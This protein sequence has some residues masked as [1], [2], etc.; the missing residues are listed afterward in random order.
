M[1]TRVILMR[2]LAAAWSLAALLAGAAPAAAQ[3]ARAFAPRFSVNQ[4]GDIT[5]VG[6]T[7]M[8]CSGGGSCTNGRNGS[9]GKLNN[10]DFTMQYVDVDGDGSTFS[11]STADLALPAGATVT[12]AGLYWGGESSNALRNTCRFGTPI[13]GYTTLT[14]TQTDANGNDYG[15]FRD[16]T[17]L[18]QAAGVG[19]YRVANVYSNPGQS[20]KQAGW[21]L[22]V[23][24]R[25]ASQTPRNLVVFDGYGAVSAATN[26]TMTVSGFLTPPA[27]VVNTRLGVVALEGDLGYTGDAFQLNGTPLSD[28]NNP[29]NNFFNSS[30]S[31]LGTTVTAKNPD[32]LNQFGF[33]VDLVNANGMLANNA[34]SASIRLTSSNDAYYPMVVT[35]A[36]DLYAPV[37]DATN[38]TKTVVDLNG[39]DT[40]PGDLLE[41]TITM[42]NTGKDNATQCVMRDTLA[43]GLVYEPGSLQVVS[44][45]NAGVK[46]D[47]GGDDQM[48]YVA[49]SRTVVA[50]LGTGANA[51]SG[52]QIDINAVTSVRFRAR[53]ASP[54]P[55]GTVVSNQGWLAFVGGQ[56]GVAFAAASDG[57]AGASGTQP[58]TITVTSARIT[59][60]VFEDVNFGGG[61]GRTRAASAGVAR[62]GARVELYDAAGAALG[63]ATTDAAGLYTFDGW[64]AGSYQ[65]RVVNSSVTSSRPGSSAGL[66]PV[67]TFRTD[68]SGATAAPVADRV[69]GE[70]P[71]RA[72]AAANLAA[73]T[74]ASLTTATTT[75]QSVSPV[76]LGATDAT[77]VDFG[78]NF[79]TI[80]NANDAGQGSLRQFLLN[81]NA[82]T[83]AG[84]AQQGRTAGEESA[85]FMVSDGLAH[86]GLRAGLAN[87]LTGGVVRITVLSALPPLTD[88]ATRVDGGTQTS[89]VGDTNPALLGSGG[90]VGADDLA[91]PAL[92]GP[93]V[94]VRDGANLAVG[95]D[96]QAVSLALGRIAVLGFGNSPGSDAN[97]D[98]RVG[99][100][101]N[102][103][104]LESCA[105]GITATSFADPGAALRSGGDHVRVLGGD[106]GVITGS[107]LAYGTG[108]AVALTAGSNG[109]SLG[110]SELR[111]NTMAQPGLGAIVLAASGTLTASNTRISDHDGPGVDAQTGTGGDT[112]TNLTVQRNGRGSGAARIT[113][114]M[115][116]GGSGS[117][118][119]R[120][121]ITDQAGSGI[122]VAGGGANHTFTRNKIRD[123]GTIGIDLQAAG[124]NAAL[125][126][127]PYVTLNDNGDG[128]TG[129]NALLNFPVVESAVLSNGSFT[130]SGWARPGSL[131]ELFTSDGDAS[132]FGE[133]AVFVTSFTEGSGLDLDSGSSGYAGAINGVNQGS[134]FT[135]RFR[136]T[137]AAPAGVAAGVKLTAT[138]TVTGVGTSEF[139]GQV[140]VTT[141]V[142]LTGTA[143]TDANHNAQRD[144]G[145]AGTG[146][147]L[148]AK[149]VR[150]GTSNALQTVSVNAATGA[151]AF[152]FVSAG[153]YDV[154]LDQD[155][156]PADLL[157]TY[158][159]GWIGTEVSSGVRV[160]VPVNATDVS[161]LDFGLYHGSRA[162]GRVFRDDGAAGGAA[163]N[164]AA[165][166]GESAVTGVRMRLL[167]AS[168][169]GGACDSTL[170][171][172]AGAFTLWLPYTLAGQSVRIAEVDP[173]GWR[174]TG[175]GG[176]STG[177]TYDRAS[178][179]LTF[180]AVSGTRYTALGFGDVPRNQW[181]AGGAQGIPAGGVA[182][183]THRF[184]A[185]S[186]G[187][188]SFT[189][190]EAA[191]PAQPGWSMSLYRDLDCNGVADAGEPLLTA[192][193]AVTAGQSVCVV[194]RQASPA[195]APAGASDAA[196]LTAAFT[197]T[198]AVP[199]LSGDESL[200]DRT[201]IVASGGLV[202]VK[203]ADRDSVRSGQT[204]TY[205]LTYTNPGAG[206][207]SNIVIR[208]A[209]PAWTVF[210][211][212]SCV[213]SGAGIT[214]CTVSA[215][216]A[217]GA[218]GVVQWSLGGSLAPGAS[219]SVSFRVRVP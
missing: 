127:A 5:L 46:T 28:A 147:A 166:S 186:A 131:I 157:P 199:A 75:A 164:G 144:A 139:S 96:L 87:L 49:G 9:G 80:V 25:D 134:D 190:A 128:D 113:T 106:N 104:R 123:N 37:F 162:D 98:V 119:D 174:S 202:L 182:A 142:M 14:A 81:A 216:P 141:G 62:P 212:A 29:A 95:F 45:P 8:S 152:T 85:L 74:L 35:F 198:G 86:P 6:N 213:A 215:A 209:T 51:A 18:V 211:A 65:V 19:T 4:S 170:T 206:M 30:I 160:G 15:S 178:D 197:Y 121:V 109:W 114:G 11:S 103:A 100:S 66:V 34:T 7:L 39:G 32:Y 60:T 26:I 159:A 133:G 124:D 20:D 120:C 48:E 16:V 196:T 153:A 59:G 102:G 110:A 135:N 118:V 56:S 71:A 132:G 169:A 168:C 137:I 172:G 78:F 208:D 158:P 151:F 99:A 105:L 205:T 179:A 130:V 13:S 148:Y 42:R 83:N 181:A 111:G 129:G 200:V 40:N 58:T 155:A 90:V 187:S 61:A 207:L 84:L 72:D 88:A 150:S 194:A 41:Y 122:Q 188:V 79:D 145:E 76:T 177:G 1:R 163:N 55:T 93:E 214:S 219:G 77:G 17:A 33:D 107:V 44:G 201:T 54:A 82:L 24:Y 50:R 10:N 218:A 38:F 63:S 53:V 116:L 192:P 92:A 117:R 126:T 57:D 184:T 185:G 52:G 64:A 173:S 156:S 176:G 154:I 70:I 195:A 210:E 43:S 217:V 136:F 189:A 21:A 108:G 101:A 146:Q 138:A 115:R 36:T 23:V 69:G 171:D 125:G 112:W 180:T 204:I 183:Y 94:E 191:S 47:G 89:L 140:P 2:V 91:N 193:L 73:A 97:A 161:G 3:I 12:W 31:T 27:G 68:A 149:L 203:S 167:H 165:E 143:Y 67:Q 22:V 175:G